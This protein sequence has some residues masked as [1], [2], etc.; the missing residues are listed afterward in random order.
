M[1]ERIL[2]LQNLLKLLDKNSDVYITALTTKTLRQLY[3]Q[4]KA[5]TYANNFVE[6]DAI[7]NRIDGIHDKRYIIHHEGKVV[8]NFSEASRVASLRHIEKLKRKLPDKNK[9]P[10]EFDNITVEIGLYEEHIANIDAA[11]TRF[12]QVLATFNEEPVLSTGWGTV[13]GKNKAIARIKRDNRDYDWTEKNQYTRRYEL[14]AKQAGQPRITEDFA[15][16]A[17][18]VLQTLKRYIKRNGA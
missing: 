18:K 5:A 8:G 15:N 9:R 10:L 4:K 11:R 13:L 6:A 14:W 12:N 7:Q 2:I 1:G 17:P 16:N 3:A